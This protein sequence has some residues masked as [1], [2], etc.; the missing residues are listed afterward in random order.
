MP[1]LV[2]GVTPSGRWQSVRVR[3]PHVLGHGSVPAGTGQIA[4]SGRSAPAR[5]DLH[6]GLPSWPGSR[7]KQAKAELCS[8]EI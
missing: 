7:D 6:A 3:A 8:L 2:S 1:R 5:A 4:E